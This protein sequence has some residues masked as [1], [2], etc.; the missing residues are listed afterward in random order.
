MFGTMGASQ[1]LAQ[2][3]DFRRDQHQRIRPALL[4][5]QNSDLRPGLLGRLL[6]LTCKQHWLSGSIEGVENSW[7]DSG[8]GS[9]N[10]GQVEGVSIKISANARAHQGKR[11][12]MPLVLPTIHDDA[13]K[14]GV[15][16][17]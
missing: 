4:L 9:P 2:P 15:V 3:Q 8:A 12:S 7:K 14:F 5:L 10:N 13:G 16:R 17:N 6:V 1:C 11:R